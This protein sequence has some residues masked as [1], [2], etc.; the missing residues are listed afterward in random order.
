[1]N[2]KEQFFDG[3]GNNQKLKGYFPSLNNIIH[4]FLSNNMEDKS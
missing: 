2:K 3:I 4:L 1:M